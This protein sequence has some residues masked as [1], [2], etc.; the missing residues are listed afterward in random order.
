MRS[1]V[2]RWRKKSLPNLKVEA[3]QV[4]ADNAEEIAAWCGGF[5]VEEI[6]PFDS[7]ARQPGINVPCEYGNE[8]ASVGHFVFKASNG[9]FRI[10]KPGEFKSLWELDP[11]K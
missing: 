11:K 7:E 9:D 4:T 8:R 2:S 10:R 6:D 1:L 5:T 3:A